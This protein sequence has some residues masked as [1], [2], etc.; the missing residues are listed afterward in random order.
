MAIGNAPATQMTD[1]QLVER[2]RAIANGAISDLEH[3]LDQIAEFRT[4][5]LRL[6][7]TVDGVSRERLVP[8]LTLFIQHQ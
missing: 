4:G 1:A 6:T 3:D 2:L 7:L 5:R 8:Q